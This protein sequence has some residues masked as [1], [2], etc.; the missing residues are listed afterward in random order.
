MSM[1][2][3]N[4]FLWT[5]NDFFTVNYLMM[6]MLKPRKIFNQSFKATKKKIIY[7]LRNIFLSRRTEVYF[8]I[9]DK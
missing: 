3:L 4:A 8:S 9:P 7:D 2:N 1:L 6:C 5:L